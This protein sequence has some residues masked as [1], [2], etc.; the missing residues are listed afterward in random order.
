VLGRD[1]AIIS[2]LFEDRQLSR[3]GTVA[4]TTGAMSYVFERAA[5]GWKIV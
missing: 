5:D 1:A 4:T 2:F 3:S